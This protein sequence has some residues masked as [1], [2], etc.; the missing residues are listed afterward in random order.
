MSKILIVD[1]NMDMKSLYEQKLKNKYNMVF[2]TDGS[3]ALKLV[4][5]H[6]D[7]DIIIT[8]TAI[9]TISGI[10]LIKKI[11]LMDSVKKSIV[12]SFYGD[13]DNI[14]KAIGVG[15]YDFV[16]KPID[17]QDLEHTINKAIQEI[18]RERQSAENK[19]KLIKISEEI[20]S[21]AELQKSILPDNY[22]KT[23]NIEIYARN[24]PANEVGGDFY[25]FFVI[26]ASHVGVVIA[27]VSGKNLS[28][29][30]FMSMA[31][32]LLKSFGKLIVNPKHCLEI[33][34]KSISEDNKSGMFVTCFYAVIDTKK[35]KMFFVN[36]G[37]L[38]PIVINKK[39][40]ISKLKCESG[41]PIGVLEDMEYVLEEYDIRPGD[42]ILFY[43]DGVCEATNS[44]YEE[45]GN[46]RFI[47][48]LEKN[49]E[50]PIQELSDA[51]FNSVKDFTG[52]S[53]QF[54]DITTLCI[55]YR[56]KL[57]D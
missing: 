14:R 31:K 50:C 3:E 25:D 36:A 51:V 52:E 32:L 33:F 6:K 7:I 26:D 19:A 55:K 18:S 21:T 20:D 24:D 49:K 57:G 47:S 15:A 41:L 40:G 16:I 5:D 44:V 42:K 23:D 39:L 46:E 54:D 27:D 30:M 56:H 8:D 37:H 9:P 45:Y 2:S 11:H 22:F 34:N 48:I 38:P 10:D 53:P 43:T 12:V 13:L 17:F 28:A 35:N 1:P 4:E 29:A